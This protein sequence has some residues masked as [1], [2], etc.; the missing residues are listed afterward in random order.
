MVPITRSWGER[1][2]SL[3]EPDLAVGIPVGR[4]AVIGLSHGHV[5]LQ[6]VGKLRRLLAGGL[7]RGLMRVSTGTA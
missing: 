5:V 3:V 2:A 1:A 6:V 4:L 7:L